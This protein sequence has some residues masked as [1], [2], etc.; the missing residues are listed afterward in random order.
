MKVSAKRHSV[1]PGILRNGKLKVLP[2][3]GSKGQANKDSSDNSL[4]D[5][6]GF[7]QTGRKFK[8]VKS[9]KRRSINLNMEVGAMS[10]KAKRNYMSLQSDELEDRDI[11]GA[12]KKVTLNLQSNLVNII[13]VTLIIAYSLIT[14]IFTAIPEDDADSLGVKASYHTLES[15]FIIVFVIEVAV[16][17]YAFKEMYF[18]NKFNFVNFILVVI[19]VVFWILDIAINNFTVSVLLRTRGAMRLFH[20]PILLENIKSHLKLQ[21]GLSLSNINY[22]DEEKP[23]AERVIE[24]LMEVNE[25]LDDPKFYNDIN[26]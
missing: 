22:K 10:I 16:H 20:I 9:E 4:D 14:F 15:L 24:I 3:I 23:T 21:K 18:N 26:F 5:G 19:I 6:T 11:F 7:S 25:M 13:I 2:S 1:T 8:G 17:K 12:R